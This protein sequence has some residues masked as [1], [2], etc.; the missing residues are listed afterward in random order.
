M[1][2]ILYFITQ[3]EFG[4]AQRYVFD[5]AMN[6][7]ADFRVAVALGEPGENGTLAKLLLKNNIPYFIIPHLKRG[8]SPLKEILALKE[9]MKLLKDYRPDIIHLNS[10]KI[11]VLGSIAAIFT[12]AKT[13]YTVHG[14]VFNEPLPAAL[15]WFYL[16]LEKFA[17]RFKDKIICV[18]E[19]DRQSALKHKIAPAE[20]LITIPNG[21]AP[22][23]FHSPEQAKKILN[24]PA[25][26]FLIGAIGNLYKTKGYEYFI[27]TANILINRRRL[28]ATFIII[29]EGQERRHLENL[30]KKY[31]L[32]N[33][34]IL[35]GGIEEAAK[36]L[37][38]FDVYLCSS[39]KE[40]LPYSILEAMQAGRPI[41]ATRVG[42]IPEMI[43]EGKTG[44]LARSADPKGLAEKIKT[45]LDNK[46]LAEKLGQSA[47]ASVAAEFSLEKMI[48]KTKK[49]YLD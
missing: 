47:K 34:F 20:K 39:V 18:S 14:W 40:G 44:L 49:A 22:L 16:R 42:G 12:K 9:I 46:A 27:E 33:N 19:A 24:R 26:N 13:V 1:Q 8:I 25:A 5:L 2:K 4:G 6:L 29:G 11:S 21:L 17:A 48:E 36:L 23:D 10:S 35:T 30:I 37:P 43:K 41:V 45:L 15:K 3:S 32:K 38:A 31:H 7:K 28:S